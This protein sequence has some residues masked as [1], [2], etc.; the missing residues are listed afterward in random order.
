M[1]LSSLGT[2]SIITRKCTSILLYLHEYSGQRF[3]IHPLDAK[4]TTLQ[5][6][7]LADGS[8]VEFLICSGAFQGADL[9]G[10]QADMILGDIFLRNVY[11]SCVKNW[12]LTHNRTS[13]HE[14]QV[15]LRFK[16]R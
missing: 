2:W 6:S 5:V 11:T 7:F 15:Q 3:P 9:S 12:N 13:S 16:G 4:V 10:E 8:R 1:L 14:L